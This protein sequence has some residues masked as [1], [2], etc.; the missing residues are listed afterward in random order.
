VDQTPPDGQPIVTPGG[1]AER[2]GIK[3]G[4]LIVAFEGRPVTD[5]DELIVAIRAQR[6]GD[7]V[8]LTVRRGGHD[9]KVHL[10][11]EKAESD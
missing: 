5:P 8:T 9:R 3:P 10:V 4:D 7:T 11:L 2:A 1:P 6:P